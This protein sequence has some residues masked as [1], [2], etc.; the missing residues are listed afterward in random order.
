MSE[1]LNVPQIG[2]WHVD[3]EATQRGLD[4][5]KPRRL[6]FNPRCPDCW[7]GPPVTSGPGPMMHIAHRWGPCQMRNFET[8]KI[9][10]CTST[11]TT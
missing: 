11:R 6:D 7:T 4:S 5:I 1:N 9:C 2:G 8:G 10:G 3:E